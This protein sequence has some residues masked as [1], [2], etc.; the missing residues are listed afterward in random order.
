[1]WT[2][3]ETGGTDLAVR[4]KNFE[5]YALLGLFQSLFVLLGVFVVAIGSMR[6]SVKV[7]IV[8]E[9]IL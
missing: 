8:P 7:N 3:D 9:I 1:M 5:G 6:S 4:N 2:K